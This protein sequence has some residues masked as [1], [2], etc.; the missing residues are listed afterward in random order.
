MQPV[1]R[2]E[3]IM[4]LIIDSEFPEHCA[5]RRRRGTESGTL[6]FAIDQIIGVGA[7]NGDGADEG[8]F[9]RL[10]CQPGED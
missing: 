10:D 5:G 7:V 3:L 1:G 6:V 2:M 4:E 9:N 8:L